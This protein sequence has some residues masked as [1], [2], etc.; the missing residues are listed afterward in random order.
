MGSEMCI[1]DR[2]EA[3]FDGRQEDTLKAWRRLAKSL[4]PAT[5]NWF[6]A[7]LNV[8]RQLELAGDREAAKKLLL[9]TR[10]VYGWE[11]SVWSDDLDRLLRL[12]RTVST[13]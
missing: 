11:K 13:P 12:L 4:T 3:Q 7:R 6:E 1:R 8:A 10:S 9:Y 5:E 2:S